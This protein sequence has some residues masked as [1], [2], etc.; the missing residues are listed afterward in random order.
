M[1]VAA[2]KAI[3]L[4]FTHITCYP[5]FKIILLVLP[6]L[7]LCIGVFAQTK[8]SSKPV[9]VSGNVQFTNNGVAPV[10]IFALG[11]PAVLG[12]TVIRKGNFYFNPEQ[13]FGLD[14]KPWT[15][16]ARFGYYLV[17]N[18]KLTLGLASNISLFFLQRDP[19]KNNNEEFQTQR[20]WS[21]EMNGEYR[22][23]PDRKFLFSYWHTICLDKL[24][25]AR[26]EFI[27]LI[28]VMEDMKIGA[29]GFFTFKPSAFYLFDS[30]TLQ[31]VFVSQTS[32]YRRVKWKFDIFL[33]TALPV[34][35]E[36]KNSFIWNGG[37][38]VPF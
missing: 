24:G 3:K 17:D 35:V 8:D 23:K 25:I 9:T 7:C 26:E 36:P 1:K 16:N 32:I 6:A 33:Q 20:Y 12:S 18:K 30:G 14:A 21:N 38:D 29:K 2:T 10:P 19:A 11:R 27:N 31:G 37:I 28:Y 15:I 22:F 4:Y 13:F 34:K 5:R